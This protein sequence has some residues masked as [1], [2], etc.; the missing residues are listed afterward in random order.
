MK[1]IV[2][3]PYGPAETMQYRDFDKPTLGDQDELLRVR[4]AGLDPGVWH[5]MTGRPS[6]VL[7]RARLAEGSREVRVGGSV[8]PTMRGDLL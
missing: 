2:Q 5:M 8:V 4:A 7:L 6:V 3:D 1:A